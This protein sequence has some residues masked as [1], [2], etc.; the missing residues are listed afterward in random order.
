MLVHLT[1]S[2]CGCSQSLL[3]CKASESFHLRL[4]P[5]PYIFYFHLSHFLLVYVGQKSVYE[6]S[7]CWE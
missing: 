7:R 3:L 1:R 2:Q 6:L 5:I 4:Y